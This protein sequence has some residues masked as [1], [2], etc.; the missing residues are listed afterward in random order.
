PG[1]QSLVQLDRRED[2]SIE[3]RVLAP[4]TF[5]PLLSGMLD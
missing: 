1:G 2:G 3:Q 5:V 4:V